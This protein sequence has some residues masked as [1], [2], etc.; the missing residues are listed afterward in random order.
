MRGKESKSQS[1]SH[2]T[3]QRLGS[4]LKKHRKHPLLCLIDD[5]EQNRAETE[6]FFCI[7]AVLSLDTT[8]I[9]SNIHARI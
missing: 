8:M 9:K 2:M 6:R 3:R 4:A 7:S 1:K 5:D